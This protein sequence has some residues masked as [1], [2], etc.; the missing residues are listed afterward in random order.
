MENILIGTAI[1]W[2]LS[3]LL[4]IPLANFLFERKRGEL[5][6]AAGAEARGSEA[7]DLAGLATQCFILAD[8]LVLG[9]AG[10]VAGLLGYWFF[11]VSFNARGWPGIVAFA[12]ASLLGVHLRG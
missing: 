9:T 8:V 7:E 1:L 4:V 12:A 2:G 6:C 11:G 3:A 10:L 5:A